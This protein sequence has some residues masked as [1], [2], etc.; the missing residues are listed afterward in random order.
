MTSITR[1]V[2][3]LSRS[4]RVVADDRPIITIDLD[5][6]SE[7]DVDAFEAAASREERDAIVERVTGQQPSC[8]D[9]EVVLIV[10]PAAT[11]PPACPGLISRSSME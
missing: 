6:W 10:V 3:R 7:G 4:I 9:D 2:D 5:T 11:D 1:R 8:R